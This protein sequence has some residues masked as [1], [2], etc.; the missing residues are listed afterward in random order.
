MNALR[1]AKRGLLG[2]VSFVINYF[3]ILTIVF[4]SESKRKSGAFPSAKVFPVAMVEYTKSSRLHYDH[5]DV[6]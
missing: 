5:E 4:L 1:D 3:I 6:Y 2:T